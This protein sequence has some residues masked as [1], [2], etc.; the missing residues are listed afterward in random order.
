MKTPVIFN[1]IWVLLLLVMACNEKKH[2]TLLVDLDETYDTK[3]LKM[4]DLAT[5]V[6]C[7][8]LETVEDFVV[9]DNNLDIWV[10]DKYIVTLSDKDIRLFSGDGK[11]LRKLASAG[12]GPDEYFYVLSCMVDEENDILYYGH[13]GDWASICAI[14]LKTGKALEKLTTGCLPM[15]MRMV[16]GN[17]FCI[18]ST[19]NSRADYSVFTITPQ[20]EIIDSLPKPAS[21]KRVI[22]L[23][24]TKLI[25]GIGKELFIARNDSVYKFDYKNPS[26]L[27]AFKYTGKFDAET[28]P[29]GTNIDV[30]L[31][32]RDGFL[33][34]SQ[35]MVMKKNG[36][37]T[38]LRIEA[39]KTWQLDTKDG[40][41][42]EIDKLYVDPLDED[43]SNPPY[44][45]VTGK[46]ICWK[47]SAF[48]VKKLADS[49]REDGKELSP[50]L[51]QLDEQ[52]TEQSNPVIIVGDLK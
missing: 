50:V 42:F 26:L 2:E 11:Y 31:K 15:Y 4:S 29:E 28:N 38:S 18:P 32:S 49:K 3:T 23:S 39:G 17:I 20:G 8:P 34:R 12:K 47:L 45:H 6:R 25:Q 10:S 46:K 9:P 21:N 44:L 19:Y 35:H 30:I 14:D 51:Q 43:Y 41:M 40:K 33:L 52:L 1:W 36:N 22:S 27:A 13:Q 7:I 48:D 24:E 5:N 16:D 37:S